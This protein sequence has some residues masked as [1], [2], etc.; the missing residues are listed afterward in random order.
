MNG[1]LTRFD[2]LMAA[3]TFAEANVPELSDEFL[4]SGRGG[5]KETKEKASQA[6]RPTVSEKTAHAGAH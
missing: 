6:H 1:L 2:K 3:I 4:G 5:R